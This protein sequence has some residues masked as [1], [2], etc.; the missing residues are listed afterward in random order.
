MLKNIFY[1]IKLMRIIKKILKEENLLNNLSNIFSTN[2][3]R[4]IFKTDW[5][6]RIYAVINPLL[7]DP[8][9]RIFEYNTEGMNLNSFIQKWIIEHMIA[10]DN[11]VKNH[12]LFDILTYEI[13]Q[14]DANHNFLFILTPISWWD[15][16]KS[17]KWLSITVLAVI[18][19]V[20]STIIFI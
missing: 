19:L 5:I 10:A 17:V 8:N 18:L 20:I 7:A 4:V 16:K 6:G 14:L 12:E 9:T 15:F 3:H 1:H 13:K 11:F 2:E